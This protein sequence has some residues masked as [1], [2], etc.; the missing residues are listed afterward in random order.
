MSGRDALRKWM[1][2]KVALCVRFSPYCNNLWFWANGV[3]VGKNMR[4]MGKVYLNIMGKVTIGDNFLLTSGCGINPI[5]S[6]QRAAFYV[7]P[8]AAVVIGDNVG[9]SGTRMWIAKGLTIGNNVCIGAG[10]LLID[11]DCHQMDF[12]MRRLEA[13]KQFT[14]TE[15]SSSIMSA[16]IVIEDDVWIGAHAIILKGVTIGARSVIGAGSVVT[17]SVPADSVVAGNPARIIHPKSK[18]QICEAN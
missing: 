5:S 12:R 8:S 17:K 7:E 10:V 11:T 9:M 1:N 18:P 13:E 14:A 2:L 3:A 4:V 16:P 6:N 15:L